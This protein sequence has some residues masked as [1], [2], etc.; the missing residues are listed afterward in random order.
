MIVSVDRKHDRAMVLALGKIPFP[1]VRVEGFW[2]RG[3][4]SDEDLTRN[5]EPA[6]DD[7][8]TA[9]LREAEAAYRSNPDRF[10]LQYCL[11][12]NPAHHEKCFRTDVRG[13]L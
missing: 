13:I 7:E 12:R 8:K 6:S 4:F 1:I 10:I 2:R 9:L 11:D 3:R 5:F